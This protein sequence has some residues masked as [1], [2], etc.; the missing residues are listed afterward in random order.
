MTTM[1]TLISTKE[2][3][4]GI[5]YSTDKR[6]VLNRQPVS[7]LLKRGQFLV[8]QSKSVGGI[9]GFSLHQQTSVCISKIS[10]CSWPCQRM[11]I[12]SVCLLRVQNRS[13]KAEASLK[14]FIASFCHIL[15]VKEQAQDH[16]RFKGR[17]SGKDRDHQEMRLPGGAWAHIS[18]GTTRP[19][20]D[21]DV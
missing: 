15:L 20:A 3:S 16:S 10:V 13:C 5:I 7:P 19:N 4:K 6:S 1:T 18:K 12:S 11:L 17:G 8:R 14:S 2:L 9:N 21:P